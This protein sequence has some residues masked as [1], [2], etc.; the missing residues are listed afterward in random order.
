M[1]INIFIFL[2]KPRIQE[3]PVSKEIPNSRVAWLDL[4]LGPGTAAATAE[5]FPAVS[6][7]PQRP[8]IK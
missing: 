1:L 4:G 8:G 6:R 2:R 3:L 5:E 7:P